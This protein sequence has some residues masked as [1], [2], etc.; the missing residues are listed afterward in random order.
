[1]ITTITLNPCLDRTIELEDLT[2]GAYNL[3]DAVR[4]DVSGKGIN[5]SVV[6]HHLGMPTQALFFDYSQGGETIKDFLKQQGIP[7]TAIPVEGELRV[8]MKL[9]D[10]KRG[11]LTEINERGNLIDEQA[12][13]TLLASLSELLKETDILVVTGSVPPGIP[14]DIYAT[15]TR[16]AKNAGVDTV[17][18]ACGEL[19][20]KGVAAHPWLVKPNQF[21]LETY[22]GEKAQNR[23][24]AIEMAERLLKDG[25]ENVCLSLGDQGAALLTEREI[26]YTPGTRI[27]A[28]GYQGAGDSLVAGLCTAKLNGLPAKEQLRWAVA[29]AQAS[30]IRSGTQLCRAEDFQA[31][32]KKISVEKI[33]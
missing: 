21:E 23:D 26:W 32:L 3:V 14:Q 1:M 24:Q 12:L 28:E 4:S 18:D 9:T 16:M 31:M 2:L 11:T 8:N 15:M 20:L 22:C 27:K 30:L 19:F 33:R 25:A 6:L 7:F 29:A 5:V 13:E 10:T 17:V